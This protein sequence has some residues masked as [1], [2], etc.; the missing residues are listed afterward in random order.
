MS[1]LFAVPPDVHELTQTGQSVPVAV[2]MQ[3]GHVKAGRQQCRT[4]L[5][6]LSTWCIGE[7]VSK[8]LPSG[9]L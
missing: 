4:H 1:A 5:S 9:R 6:P 2:P 7:A 8:P 3:A